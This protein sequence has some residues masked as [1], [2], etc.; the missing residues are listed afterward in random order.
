MHAYYYMYFYNVANYIDG[1][2]FLDL[3]DHDVRE[4]VPAIG[5]AKKISR[6]IPKSGLQVFLSTVY[7]QIKL[8]PAI[9]FQQVVYL[10]QAFIYS[11]HVYMH[12]SC[13]MSYILHA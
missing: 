1:K 8:F 4:M 6:L 2:E 10:R 12:M 3:T 7:P 13:L 9:D 11:K 5:I